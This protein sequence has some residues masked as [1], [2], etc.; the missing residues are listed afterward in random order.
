MSKKNKYS[1]NPTGKQ[2]FDAIHATNEQKEKYL[3]HRQKV[4]LSMTK[5]GKTRSLTMREKE[6][7]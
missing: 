3:G 4:E 5:A 2:K 1:V 6:K 7:P